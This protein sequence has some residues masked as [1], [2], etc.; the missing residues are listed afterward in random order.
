ML[1]RQSIFTA[2]LL[3]ILVSVTSCG[4]GNGPPNLP[5]NEN[6]DGY[7]FVASDLTR[8]E[9]PN[10]PAGDLQELVVGNSEFAFDI[11]RELASE[12]GNIFFSPF[13]ISQALAMTWAGAR[14]NTEAQIADTMH[15]TLGQDGLHPAFNRLDLELQSR[16]EGAAGK[17]GEGFRLNI[18]NSTW[19]QDGWTWLPG[20]LDVL[21]L[22]YG[23]GMRLVDFQSDPE[24]CR[25]TI[26][27]WVEEKTEDRIKDLLP[28]GSV[29][30]MTTLVL[31]NAIY[32]NAAWFEPFEEED[33]YSGD[34]T[35]LDESTLTTP[36]MFQNEE[37]G[38]M[39]GDGFKACEIMY[40]GQELS[41][42]IILPDVGRFDEIESWLS[43]ETVN[44]I[45]GAMGNY[46]VDLT[47]PKF[48]YE[49]EFSLNDTLYG[50][51]MTDAFTPGVADFSGMDGSLLLYITDVVHKA[52]VAVDE[53]GTEAAAATGVVIGYTSIPEYAEFK[54]DHPFIF[55]IR[56]L[57]TGA[58]LFLGR[59]V[60]PTEGGE[61]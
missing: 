25:L 51:G 59:V 12:D 13:S 53:A 5:P 55:F 28:P 7:K 56:D 54:A 15:F 48:G 16:G 8:D 26:N 20:F 52:F 6:P 60:D 31:V 37:H 46:S 19:G 24:S 36:L 2:V 29:D 41:M 44:G 21:A 30:A 50:M 17:D 22:N 43:A 9:D 35:L 45:I 61:A 32:F 1:L 10:V 33:T 40:D 34:F 11:Y 58:I 4:S 57:E 27:D 38:Y 39:E 3:S 42:V 47:M 14:N 23:A 18:A 49:S